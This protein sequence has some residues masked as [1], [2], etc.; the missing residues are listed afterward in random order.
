M[1]EEENEYIGFKK[2]SEIMGVSIM[3]VAERWKELQV[4]LGPL[5]VYDKYE[6]SRTELMDYWQESMISIRIDSTNNIHEDERNWCEDI[7][8]L[9]EHQGNWLA[10][11]SQEMVKARENSYKLAVLCAEIK[12]MKKI[13]RLFVMRGG[14]N[15]MN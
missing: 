7:T 4:G 12:N 8:D 3:A 2:T 10:I 1:L 9:A 13:L 5:V 15:Y 14:E 6:Q 11:E